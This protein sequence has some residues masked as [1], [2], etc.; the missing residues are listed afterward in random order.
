[1][2]SAGSTTTPRSRRRSSTTCGRR[3]N[4]R[5]AVVTVEDLT[6]AGTDVGQAVQLEDRSD[7][8]CPVPRRLSASPASRP[9]AAR[10]LCDG[11][12]LLGQGRSLSDHITCR[13]GIAGNAM[14][15]HVKG[16]NETA[17]AVIVEAALASPIGFTI[18][19]SLLE[20]GGGGHGPSTS[21]QRRP[22]GALPGRGQHQCRHHPADPRTASRSAWPSRPSGR[23]TSKSTRPIRRRGPTSARWT[24]AALGQCIAVQVSGNF[25]PIIPGLSLLPNPLALTTKAVM[26]SEAN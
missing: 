5:D 18:L 13:R 7:R 24:D 21:G 16:I 6:M 17:S 9:P 15:N 8:H 23:S 25:T 14:R 2:A 19:L 3:A 4:H 26:Q 11:A 10:K 12:S 1:M 22:R 20:Y